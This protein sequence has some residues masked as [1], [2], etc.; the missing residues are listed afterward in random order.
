MIHFSP[1]GAY[2]ETRWIPFPEEQEEAQQRAMQNG[3]SAKGGPYGKIAELSINGQVA[4][5][6]REGA[7]RAWTRELR[8][9]AGARGEVVEAD[10]VGEEGGE[11]ESL[12][13]ELGGH[14]EWDWARGRLVLFIGEYSWIGRVLARDKLTTGSSRRC[15]IN[16]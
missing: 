14:G 11:G 15:L 8:E 16:P 7:P 9:W 4:E 1:S 3:I 6:A 13:F 5:G 10:I 2:N 12:G